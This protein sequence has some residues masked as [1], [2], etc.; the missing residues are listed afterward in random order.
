M[1]ENEKRL[2][3]RSWLSL[4]ANSLALTTHSSSLGSINFYLCISCLKLKDCSAVTCWGFKWY[5]YS[6]ELR[7]YIW[8]S[9]MVIKLQL[10]MLI[11]Y[12]LLSEMEKMIWWFWPLVNYIF[13]SFKNFNWNYRLGKIIT[14]KLII[15]VS[16]PIT[17][18]QDD[19]VHWSEN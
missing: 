13:N 16:N 5:K 17:S 6:L 1:V 12:C 8:Q 3:A 11:V 15:N 2:T 18:L 9:Q 7:C 4:M 19:S 14:N 10:L